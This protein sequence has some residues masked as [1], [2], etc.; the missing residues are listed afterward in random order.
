MSHSLSSLLPAVLAWKKTLICSD[1]TQI[2]RAQCGDGTHLRGI[3]GTAVGVEATVRTWRI[4]SKADRPPPIWKATWSALF[5][6]GTERDGT[7]WEINAGTDRDYT[8]PTA[9]EISPM[10]AT[11]LEL[12]GSLKYPCLISKVHN[13]VLPRSKSTF[14]GRQMLC[15]LWFALGSSQWTDTD[16]RETGDMPDKGPRTP[17]CKWLG[18]ALLWWQSNWQQVRWCCYSVF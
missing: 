18:R 17:D 13:L 3:R 4:C 8:I 15:R 1:N 11:R 10:A 9:G 2:K 12:V 6:R 14:N 5:C 7:E 16:W